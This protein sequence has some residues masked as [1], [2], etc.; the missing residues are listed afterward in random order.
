MRSVPHPAREKQA[1]RVKDLDVRVEVIQALIPL[2]LEHVQ[3]LLAEEVRALAGERHARKASTGG[4]V[5]WGQQPGSV[6][7]ADQKLPVRVPRVR[8]YQRN[9]EIPLTVYQRLQEPR[10]QDEGVFRRILYGLSCRNYGVCAEAVPEA[11]GLSGSTIS[12]RY[13][14]ATSRK[15]RQLCERRL[16][17]YDFVALILDGKTFAEDGMVIAL[18]VTLQGRKVILGFVQTASENERVLSQFLQELLERGLR[19]GA[20]LLCVLDG[21]KGMHKAVWSVLGSEV[22]IQ[23]CQ[24]HKRKNV[25]EYLPKAQ[26]DL[27]RQKLQ[28]AYEQ[29]E[30]AQAKGALQRVR[31]E[32]QGINES[33]VRSLDEGLEETLTLHRLGVFLS[34]G[35]SLKTTNCLESLLAQ[36][37]QWTDKVDRWQN[38]S[39]KQRWVASALLEIEPRLRR[40]RGY[41]YLPQLRA[42]L[43]ARKEGAKIAAA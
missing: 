39:Q 40:I 1:E 7:L 15:L 34:L 25:L 9:H 37:G 35:V 13:V 30:Y 42:A 10:G 43:L 8:H 23:R 6:Y 21:S 18:G 3:E 4:Y 5:R 12:R 11:F 27:F 41:R 24:W 17:G 38:S 29:P 36:V 20:G 33:A 2:A 14:R 26:Q 31:R 22:A 19:T 16:E 32:L 28:R